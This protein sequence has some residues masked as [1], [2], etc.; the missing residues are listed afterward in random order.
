M[1]A[2]IDRSRSSADTAKPLQTQP[3]ALLQSSL[4][5]QQLLLLALLKAE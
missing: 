5:Q 3:L 1:G 2:A 4:E